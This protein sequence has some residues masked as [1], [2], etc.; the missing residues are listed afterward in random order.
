[1]LAESI[2]SKVFNLSSGDDICKETS[3]DA[4]S[5]ATVAPQN[6][7]ILEYHLLH[8]NKTSCKTVHYISLQEVVKLHPPHVRSTV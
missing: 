2:K 1:M 6:V 5:Y 4:N 3:I 8:T 7:R